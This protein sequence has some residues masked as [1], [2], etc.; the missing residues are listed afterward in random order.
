MTQN[1]KNLPESDFRKDCKSAFQ[2]LSITSSEASYLE[3]STRLQSQSKLWFDHR[4][5]RITAS[6][7][8]A[9]SKASLNPPQASLV[10]EIMGEKGVNVQGVPALDWGKK[11]EDTA[12]KE[13]LKK[14]E[15]TH[16]SLNYRSTGFHVNIRYPHLGATPDGVIE[17]ECWVLT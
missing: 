16:V 5:G 8:S 4:A 3:E 9:I 6:K 12:R 11:K 10:K 15:E 17:C 2:N 7:I 1:T 14:A 13:Y